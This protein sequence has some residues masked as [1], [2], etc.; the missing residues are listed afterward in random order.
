MRPVFDVIRKQSL[1]LQ[2]LLGVPLPPSLGGEQVESL[3]QWADFSLLPSFDIIS[4][5]FYFSVYSG[6]FSPEGFALKVFM[7]TPPQLRQ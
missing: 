3:R 5:Y 7:P 2:D 6:S 4:K 1:S